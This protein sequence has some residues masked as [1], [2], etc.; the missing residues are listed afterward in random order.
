MVSKPILI[1]CQLLACNADVLI[2]SCAGASVENG[3]TQPD[4]QAVAGRR[5]PHSTYSAD[6]SAVLGNFQVRTERMGRLC[7]L[8][9]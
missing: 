1:T 4:C 3:F 2:S 6:F 7:G 5:R 9:A 8:R